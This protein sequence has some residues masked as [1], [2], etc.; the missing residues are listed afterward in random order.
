M[1][2]QQIIKEDCS[3]YF[4]GNDVRNTNFVCSYTTI[5]K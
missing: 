4:L 2:D 3:Y 5:F 1:H